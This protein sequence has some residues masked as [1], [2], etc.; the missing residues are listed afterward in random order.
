MSAWTLALAIAAGVFVGQVAALNLDDWLDQ[1]GRAARWVW[2]WARRVSVCKRGRHRTAT[3]FAPVGGR[4]DAA[5]WTRTTTC[6]DCRAVT[7]LANVARDDVP[8][9][10]T[11]EFG[12]FGL[13]ILGDLF[14]D[15]T[16]DGE[17]WKQ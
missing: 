9:L 8:W 11:H 1:G 4:S 6:R 16:T 13:P 10:Y 12:L 7:S 14:G 2:S 3:T 5:R 15:S 17:E